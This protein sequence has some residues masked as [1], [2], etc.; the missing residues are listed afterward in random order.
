MST[1][2]QGYELNYLDIDKQFLVVVKVV[3][4]FRRYILKNHTNV[5][6][7]TQLLDQCWYNKSWEKEGAI[8]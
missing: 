6:V 7:P 5:I 4:E 3:N 2:L 1:W 8:G